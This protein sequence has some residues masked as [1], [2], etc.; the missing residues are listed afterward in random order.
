MRNNSFNASKPVNAYL[1]PTF[2]VTI[3]VSLFSPQSTKV[4][5]ILYDKTKHKEIIK[6]T[7]MR[8]PSIVKRPIT[9][10]P[11]EAKLAHNRSSKHFNKSSSMVT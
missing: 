8:K 2:D 1:L 6:T 3:P 10:V 7:M 5:R 4:L 11:N 9:M